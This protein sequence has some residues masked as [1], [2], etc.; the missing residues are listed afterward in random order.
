MPGACVST[1]IT[2][3]SEGASACVVTVPRTALT[4]VGD[5]LHCRDPVGVLSVYID[6]R[7]AASA[8]NA[9]VHEV[10]IELDKLVKLLAKSSFGEEIGRRA[11]AVRRTV[12]GA[13]DPPQGES[14]AVF[15]SLGGGESHLQ[16]LVAAGESR[17]RL[18]PRP[19]LR[20]LCVALQA[21]DPAGV[22]LLDGRGV[23]VL[24]S[25]GTLNELRAE[26]LPELEEPDLVGPVHGHV[27]GL[28]GSAP[29]FKVSQQ[30]DL[31]ERRMASEY[32]RFLVGAGHRISRLA[33][34]RGWGDL[35]VSGDGEWPRALESALDH[36]F[37][38]ILAPHL[39]RGRSLG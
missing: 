38:V 27:R 7:Q 12:D 13:L 20:P 34:D 3:M 14:F 10:R 31:Y 33:T 24:E 15:A 29:G 39:E 17:I 21:S 18:G 5:L 16:P 35:V 19:D 8:G 28:P 22:V 26:T 37:P 11:A 9:A 2:L 6:A 30:R 36:R 25:R 4:G 23:R 32:E 1:T